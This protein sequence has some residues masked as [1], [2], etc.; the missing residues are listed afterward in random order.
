MVVELKVVEFMPEFAGKLNF[1]VSAADHLLRSAEDNPTIGLLICRSK[2]ETIVQWSL[3]GVNKPVG[4]A[5]Y[6][7]QEIVEET[8]NAKELG[9]VNA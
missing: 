9:S 3:E 6:Q 8:L 5:S 7:L 2:D 1:Y 4:V